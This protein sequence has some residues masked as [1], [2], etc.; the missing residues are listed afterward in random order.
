MFGAVY[1]AL[2]GEAAPKLALASVAELQ[3]DF[4]TAVRYYGTVW[5]TDHGY[6]SAAF[7][8]ARALRGAGERREAVAAVYGAVP[9][10]STHHTAAQESALR[11]LLIGRERDLTASDLADIDGRYRWLAGRLDPERGNRLALDVFAATLGALAAGPLPVP[12]GQK[13]LDRAVTERD[14]RFGMESAY[15]SL[16][17]LADDR[18]ARIELVDLANSVRPRTLV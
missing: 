8:L 6:V 4:A 15:R 13:L 16:A 17:R 18:G 14:L 9:E 7:G 5:R 1:D 10:T 12:S 2:P 11:G 3:G